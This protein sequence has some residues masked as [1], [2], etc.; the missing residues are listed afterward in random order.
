MAPQDEPLRTDETQKRLLDWGY[1]QPP[2]ERLAEQILD[3]E[4]YKDIDPSHPLGGPDGGRDGECTRDG[5]KGVWAV[6]FPRDQQSLKD[7][8]DK[9]AADIEA[10]R[11]HNPKFLVFVTN[12]E[13]R[14][15]ERARLRSLGGDIR[16]DLFHLE[17]VA[18]ILDRPYM[19]PVREQFLRIPAIGVAPMDITASV[20]GTAY[21][22]TDDARLL[23]AWVA[24]E[25]QHIRKRS[26]E[27]HERV[28]K[29]QAA[30]ERA[31][32]AEREKQARKAAA[33]RARAALER[34]WDIAA[35]IPAWDIA[36]H[37]SMADLFGHNPI[38][39]NLIDMP[40]LGSP[41]LAGMGEPPKRPE[42][43]SE[44]QIQDEVAQYRGELEG[45]WPACRDY[46]ASV[47][48]PA[49]RLRIWNAA[50]S[51]LTDVQVILTFH[52]ARGVRF[53]GVQAFEFMKVQDPD[54]C[55]PSDPRLGH[56]A[57]PMLPRLRRPDMY[58]IEWRH[59][60]DGELEV[61]VTLPQL[62]PHPEWRSE[63]HGDDVVLIA[64]PDVE[65]DEIT[66]T[67]TATAQGYGEKF[68]GDPFTVPVERAPMRDVLKDADRAKKD[69]S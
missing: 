50:E 54:W 51:F 13:I 66:V 8:E 64:D 61:T 1:Q 20:V 60:D 27:G 18:G 36:S 52:G 9:L 48:W 55:P 6:Y 56:V 43:L 5:E 28:R 24:V 3:P 11:K 63:H 42:P 39:D 33:E 17:R 58:P 69:A 46:L 34:P 19:G 4:G 2:S 53:K 59:N 15:A 68:D 7:I 25:E 29:E 44:E 31:E 38:I 57:P 47:A 35:Q 40:R 32:R 22:F 21:A 65:S 30:K 14:L 37:V 12:Q 45:R 23:D 16:I 10:A 62:R 49:L 26:E 67:Y 41:R